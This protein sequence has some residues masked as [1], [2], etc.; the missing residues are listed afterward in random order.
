MKNNFA[1]AAWILAITSVL[2]NAFVEAQ[3]APPAWQSSGALHGV[4][5]PKQEVSLSVPADGVVRKL[6]VVEGQ[7]VEADQL[8]LGMDDRV[9]RE[10][11]KVAE[12]SARQDAMVRHGA[13]AVRLAEFK[14]RNLTEAFQTGAA[15][16]FELE[17]S[18]I[19][20]AQAQAQH[21]AE[22]EKHALAAQ[23][24]ELERARLAQ[25][26]LRAPF[27]GRVVRV[28]TKI[29]ASATPSEPV[30]NLAS[31]KILKVELYLPLDM[32]GSI[33]V[34]ESY[35]LTAGSP[36]NQPLSGRLTSID[37]IIDS[38]T[39]TFRCTFEIDN[40]DEQLPAG[41]SVDFDADTLRSL[42]NSSPTVPVATTV[43]EQN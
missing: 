40:A 3:E 12:L 16:S 25:L 13:A 35:V 8:L 41:F 30:I 43:S 15:D 10:S 5:V 7:H 23:S 14:L 26:E 11:L 32:F 37:P 39:E 31:L 9:A 24:L 17:E 22:V 4:A 42:R 28:E 19:Q 18:K 6:L 2:P 38:A 29:G 1:L 34:G 20:L 36:V 21:D 27:A 33:R